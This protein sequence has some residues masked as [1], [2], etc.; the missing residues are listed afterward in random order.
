M[1]YQES[2]VIL[3]CA[4]DDNSF[5]DREYTFENMLA[6]LPVQKWSYQTA[7]HLLNRAA[8]G[9]T[10]EEIEQAR[11]KGMEAAVHD[12]LN[13]PDEPD[14]SASLPW[15]EPKNLR[16]HRQEVRKL[17]AEQEEGKRRLRAM[18]RIKFRDLRGLSYWWL[19]RMR[20]TRAP[21]LEK[22]T[23]FWHG[24]FATSSQKVR[25]AY[26]MWRQNETF[27][28]H[29]LGHFPTLLKEISRDP[30]MMIYLDLQRSLKAHPNENWAREVMELFT[31][32]V[33]NY[34]EEDIRESAR[35]FTGYRIDLRN[36]RF[37]YAALEHDD[38][39]KKFMGRTGNFSG[40]QVLDIIVQQ[41]ACAAF[42]GRKLWRYFVEDEP[43]P[44]MVNAVADSLRQHQFELRSTLRD[45]LR[46]AAFYSDRIIRSQIKA[47][48]QFLVQGS[49]LLE[50]DLPPAPVAQGAMRG[51]GQLL[52]APPSV[53]GWDGGK[54]WIS[55]STLLFRYNF[56]NYLLNGLPNRPKLRADFAPPHIDLTKIVPR[57]L[58]NKPEQ[59]VANLA[60][61]L[62]Q[63]PAGAKQTE[64]FL[65][66]LKAREPD[67]GDETMRGLLHL[68][69]ST[70]Q[71]Q[72]T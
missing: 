48:V 41:P 5:K 3:R 38:G 9:G 40:D 53:K 71:Y 68:M 2:S 4:P 1:L 12:L 62:F 51:M 58:R 66:Y 33:G 47:P 20:R 52:F 31:L 69:M 25:D 13:P 26:W 36:Q 37:Y 24:H 46:S 64:T 57:E 17:K 15:A 50:T 22:M 45:I 10:P 14:D 7:A 60:D 6:P 67:R 44:T 18:R 27:R 56:A 61:R 8:F 39:P 21:L 59:L 65:A 23:L 43:P 54:S 30:A 42:L 19:E 11:K 28:R 32:G 34:S 70:P 29:A 72:L 16:A 55:T 49:K 63:T 35:A